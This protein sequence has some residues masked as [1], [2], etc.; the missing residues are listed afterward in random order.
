MRKLK[1]CRPT[2]T[3]SLAMDETN[4]LSKLWDTMAQTL[5]TLHRSVLLVCRL[6]VQGEAIAG[7]KSSKDRR[8]LK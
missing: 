7:Q 8:A 5:R 1:F 2:V 3:S 6:D 4:W